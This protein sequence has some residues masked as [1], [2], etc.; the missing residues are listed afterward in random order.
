MRYDYVQPADDLLQY[1][2]SYYV[3]EMPEAVADIVRVEIPHIRFLVRGETELQHGDAAV[4]YPSPMTLLCGPSMGAG[5][6]AVSPGTMIVGASI[7]P[8]GWQMMVGCPMDRLADHK[9]PLEQ[10]RECDATSIIDR[11]AIAADDTDL[12]NAVDGF[13]RGLI[14]DKAPVNR[15]FMDIVMEWLLD[16]TSP[17]LDVLAS[18]VP[19]SSRQL[20]RL[21]RACFGASPKRLHRKFRILHISNTLAVTDETDWREIAGLSYF[22]QSHFIRDFKQLIGCTPGEFMR[23]KNMMI[24]FD[25][26]K[27]QEIAH[28]SQLSQIG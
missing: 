27:R 9:V 17:G 28:R 1:V 4:S 25:L 6:A 14:M 8:L 3:M 16:P 19:V 5:R 20:D 10:I 26:M 7:T 18:R 23:G 11:L 15:D 22:D 2:G 12:F 24:R 21:C 13:F